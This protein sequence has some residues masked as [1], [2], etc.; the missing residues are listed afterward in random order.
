MAKRPPRLLEVKPGADGIYDQPPDPQKAGPPL[1]GDRN[2][3]RSERLCMRARL[4]QVASDGTL[5]GTT[6]T[7]QGEDGAPKALGGLI[8]FEMSVQ[9]GFPRVS[10]L[11]EQ[12]YVYES[13]PEIGENAGKD[14]MVGDRPDTLTIDIF[15]R[16]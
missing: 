7:V 10:A 4:L 8:R 13:I 12:T 9:R 2:R 14:V 3:K 16:S 11:V 1:Q 15:E 5:K 6:I